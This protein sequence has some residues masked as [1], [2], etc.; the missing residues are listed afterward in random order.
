MYRGR[1]V[2]VNNRSEDRSENQEAAISKGRS[3][4][5]IPENW[6]GMR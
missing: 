5:L 2:T 3:E 6:H 1:V 4:V